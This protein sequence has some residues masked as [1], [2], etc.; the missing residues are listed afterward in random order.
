MIDAKSK[1]VLSILAKDCADGSYKI[2][3]IPDI[4]MALPKHFRMDSDAVKHILTHLER[5][6]IISVKYDDDDVFCLAVLPYGFEILENEKPRFIKKNA[7]KPKKAGFLT[8]FLCF[9]SSLLGSGIA[10]LFC[11]LFSL[12]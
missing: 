6:D 12:I 4:I 8:I 1:L 11:W 2:V 9:L 10:I 5:Q 7:E 3:E